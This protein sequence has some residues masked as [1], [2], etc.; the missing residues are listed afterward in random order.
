M[1]VTSTKKWN[2]ARRRSAGTSHR[3]FVMYLM[4]FSIFRFS[5]GLGTPARLVTGKVHIELNVT[6]LLVY[7]LIKLG[8]IHISV[9]VRD[10]MFRANPLQLLLHGPERC[11]TFPLHLPHSKCEFFNTGLTPI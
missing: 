8:V 11:C 4:L 10:A 5:R 9:S 7:F 6:K 1:P 3:Q 2:Y